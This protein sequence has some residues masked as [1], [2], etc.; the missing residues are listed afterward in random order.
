[1][2]TLCRKYTLITGLLCACLTGFAQDHMYSQ[3]FNSPVYLNPALTGQFEGDLRM[4]F[5]Y[6]NQFTSVPGSFNYISG[7]I[8]YNIPK[9]GGGI[10][11][12]F[13]RSSEG[14][15]YLTTNN[16][17]GTYSYSV[18]SEGFV[19]S[20]GLQAGVSNR[21]IDWSKLVF[22]DQIDP[23]LGFIPGSVSTADQPLF[24]NKFYFDSGA[25]INLAAG[26]FNVGAALQHVN[27]PNESFTGNPAILPMRFT[28]H[29]SYRWD[30]N[31]EAN[32]D[33]QQKS[34]II[35]S[36]VYYKQTTA[37]S[38]S[39]GFQYKRRSINVGLWYRSGGS[40]GPSAAVLS[41]IFDIFTTTQG[42]E[43]VRLGVSHDV[44]VSGLNYSNTS[45]TSEGSIGYETTLPSRD[46]YHKFEGAR[47]CYDF[48]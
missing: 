14:T 17:A 36:V 31:P 12:L 4:D 44:P 23:R 2:R 21:S 26:Q 37:E 7:S 16:I 6:R 19:L 20:F 32:D 42:G 3:F 15:A 34:Y 43:K 22:G 38:L 45:G 5:I 33:E 9:F 39:I 10:G 11:L 46:T 48:Y 41:L 28:G 27:K 30:L 47:R 13:T 8:D 24:N 35:P 18:G 1:M 29:L 40:N 25:G